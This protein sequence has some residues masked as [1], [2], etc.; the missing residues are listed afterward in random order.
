MTARERIQ[1]ILAS[2]EVDRIALLD[3]DIILLPENAPASEDKFLLLKADGPFQRLS[4]RYGLEGALTQFIRE[5]RNTLEFF[6]QSCENIFAEYKKKLH[7]GLRVDGIWIGEDIAYQQGL[8]FSMKSYRAQLLGVH[9]AIMDYFIDHGASVFFH[10][11]GN[12]EQLL[13]LMVEMRVSAMH[14]FEESANP[15]LLEIK[16][17][18]QG[19][20]TF[21]GGVGFTRLRDIRLI[22]ERVRALSEKGNYIFSFDGPIENNLSRNEYDSILNEIELI[23]R[24]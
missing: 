8:L 4:V 19:A 14:P 7:E 2:Q 12:I 15:N 3:R 21:I 18:L 6:K 20:M 17:D 5:P 1:G 23:G 24:A 9:R 11:D 10:C 22:T 16:N 13:P